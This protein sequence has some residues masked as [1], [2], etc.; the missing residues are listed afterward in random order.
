MAGGFVK[1]CIFNFQSFCLW[2]SHCMS[3]ADLMLKHSSYPP[4]PEIRL[5]VTDASGSRTYQH[6]AARF[7][8]LGFHHHRMAHA[9]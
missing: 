5:N 4:P 1:V 6:A 8:L 9:R 3:F 7:S 2:L